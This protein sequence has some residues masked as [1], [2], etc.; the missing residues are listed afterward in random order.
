[1]NTAQLRAG[2]LCLTAVLMVACGSPDPVAPER[3]VDTD[4]L[5]QLMQDNLSGADALR[6]VADIDHSRLGHAAGS[7][8][9][10]ARVL[11]FSDPRLDT[12]LLQLNPLTGLDL[13][14]RILAFE[15]ASDRSAKVI[16]NAFDYLV[17]RYRL[18]AEQ[19]GAL[20]QSYA[21]AVAT[22]TQGLPGDAFTAF[23]RDQMQPDGII[24][25][26]SPYGFENTLGRVNAVIDSQSDAIRFGVVDF[27]ANA[28]ALGIELPPAYLILFGAP[29]PGGKAMASSPTLG[30]DAFCQKLLVWQDAAGQTYLSFNDLHDLAERQEAKKS[31]A[32]WVI[33]FRLTSFFGDALAAK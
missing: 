12:A 28:R 31:L 7:P 5:M 30:L 11:M 26:R 8:M 9:P 23:D 33:N 27:Q 6:K 10:P 19:T 24:T 32:L 15:Q 3:Y 17:S 22:V 25:I 29:G 2:A 1:M 4:A 14:L 18:D 13:P 21:E 16:Y 20:R